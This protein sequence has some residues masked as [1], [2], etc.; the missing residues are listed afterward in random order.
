MMVVPQR[1]VAKSNTSAR[2]QQGRLFSVAL[3]GRAAGRQMMSPYVLAAAGV[4]IIIVFLCVVKNRRSGKSLPPSPPSSLPLIGHVHLIG[5]T[6]APCTS[7]TSATAAAAASSSCSSGAGG[8][9][10]CPRLRPLRTCSGTTTSP[11]PPAHAAWR[12]T[13]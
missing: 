2:N 13:G 3:I 7:C 12:R 8:R 5:P 1:P 4:L 11:S 6:T 10:W 9:W